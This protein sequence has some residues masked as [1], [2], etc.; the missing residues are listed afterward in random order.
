VEKIHACRNNYMLFHSEDAILE[1][2]HVCKT[3]RYKQND[4]N[5]DEDD[6]KNNKKV[7]RVP[8]KV[9]WYFPIIPRLRRLFMN[10]ANVELL[11]WHAREHKKD[12]MLHHPADGIHWRN[13][14]RKHK[15][16]AA[17]VRNII[18]GLSTDGMN[19]FGE[20]GSSHS[21]WPITLYIY[22]LP[23]QFCMKRKFIMIPLL[24]SG[25]VQTSNDID[26]YLKPLIDDLLVLWEK[27]GVRMWDEF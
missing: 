5:I 17:D 6:M 16:F 19:P 13:F 9:A 21:T 14:D 1:E 26:V 12:A 20:T 25:P 4:K 7:K 10:K 23:S 8:A 2:C 3:S 15:N 27:E 11:H 18:F 22:N 24:I